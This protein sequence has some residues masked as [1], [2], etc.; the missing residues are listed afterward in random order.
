[1][2]IDFLLEKI[3]LVWSIK[4]G[5]TSLF[6]NGQDITHLFPVLKESRAPPS[7]VEFTWHSNTGEKFE[8]VAR[9]A[10][11]GNKKQYDLLIDNVS[12]F[13]LPSLNRLCK[14]QRDP[15]PEH[16]DEYPTSTGGNPGLIPLTP[17]PP[18]P[19]QS[20]TPRRDDVR[21]DVQDSQSA[22]H[23]RERVRK[24]SQRH[25]VLEPEGFGEPALPA[26]KFDLGGMED[27]LRSDLYSS[28]LDLLR[29]EVAASIPETECM[30]SKAIVNAFSEDHDSDTSHDSFSFDNAIDP[31]ELEICVLAETFK[32]LKW[33]RQYISK[34]DVHDC[35]LELM[36]K[37]VEIIVAH[38]R[39]DR[40]SP[41]NASEIMLR[42]ASVLKLDVSRELIHDTIVIVGLS[43][44]TTSQDLAE[45]L[46]PFGEIASAVI[47]KT[48]EGYGLCRFTSPLSVELACDAASRQEIDVM[49]RRPQIFDVLSAPVPVDGEPYAS[50]ASKVVQELAYSFEDEEEE[51][52]H[53]MIDPSE[54]A[55][56][57]TY[58]R[59]QSHRPL[60]SS[61]SSR[62]SY[63]ESP[64]DP[65]VSNHLIQGPTF[66][67]KPN[68]T[69]SMKTLSTFV[70]DFEAELN[71]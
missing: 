16:E 8:V 60:H 24:K 58:F 15:E 29:D 59:S 28:K 6:W 37:H 62:A 19:D 57:T 31:S 63:V 32:W 71:W 67:T 9:V 14:E 26:F 33:S 36:Q 11:V 54:N 41:H 55:I 70:D 3:E 40:L 12:F 61:Y 43:S 53:H 64:F 5:K 50:G 48:H 39:H 13:S 45:S 42:V 21:E 30:M 49:S 47:C 22:A 56:E 34:Y 38:V 51:D 68:S 66:K 1:M 2:M 20:V 4:S 52:Y 65:S 18:L 35:K 7:M 25:Q 44:L 10:P 27:E 69:G 17:S 46:L 23:R